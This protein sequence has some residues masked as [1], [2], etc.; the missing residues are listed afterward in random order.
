LTAYEISKRLA[1]QGVLANATNAR[2]IRMV[3]HLD[4]NRAECERALKVLHEV[5]APQRAA[6]S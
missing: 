2:T 6:A 5:V 4:I 3:T 1:A